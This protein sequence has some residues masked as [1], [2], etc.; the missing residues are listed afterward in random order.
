MGAK[1]ILARARVLF[2]MQTLDQYT[3]GSISASLNF[4]FTG[5]LVY[6]FTGLLVYWFTGLL[7]Y[8][9]TGLLLSHTSVYLNIS[10]PLNQ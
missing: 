8:W 1:H 6:W 10:K 9:F 4:H 2:E 7:V 3:T 5:L